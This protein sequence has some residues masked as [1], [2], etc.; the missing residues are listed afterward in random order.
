MFIE[1][2][3]FFTYTFNILVKKGDTVVEDVANCG[4]SLYALRDGLQA[5]YTGANGELVLDGLGSATYKGSTWNYVFDKE[6]NDLTLTSDGNSFILGLT[7]SDKTYVE[8]GA[9]NVLIKNGINGTGLTTYPFSSNTES[10]TYVVNSDGTISLT[11]HDGSREKVLVLTPNEA[12]TT[13]TIDKDFNN[14][15]KTKGVVLSLVL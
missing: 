4:S 6:T 13:L 8:K 9:V 2:N 3:T 7:L 10:D 11:M 12:K 1:L 5:T 14:G 15:Y